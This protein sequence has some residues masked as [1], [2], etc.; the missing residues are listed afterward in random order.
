MITEIKTIH[1][2]GRYRK[3][4]MPVALHKNQVIFGFNGTG[5][6]TMSDILY[7]LSD[8]EHCA[9]LAKRK[10]LRTEKGDEPD[11]MYIV[12]G[13]ETNDLVYD[14]NSWNREYPV[15]VFNDQYMDDYVFL[16]SGHS[17][18][19][20]TVV[21]GK[22]G[23]QLS[24]KKQALQQD[25][26]S[27]FEQV[28]NTITAHKD[29]CGK[30][31]IGK[32]KIKSPGWEKR[33]SKIATI[34][35]YAPSQKAKID[36]S[37]RQLTAFDER[38]KQ[39]ERW[40]ASM[41]CGMRYVSA[42]RSVTISQLN[43]ELL[44]VPKVTNKEIS[45]H[46]AHFM[47][48]TDINWLTAGMNYQADANHCPFCGQEI[49]GNE[50]KKLSI[51][52]EKFINSRQKQK[53]DAIT[54]KM[55]KIQVFFDE[56][57]LEEIFSALSSIKEENETLNLL[58]RATTSLLQALQTSFTVE[59]G[60]FH[61]LYEKISRKIA[62]PYSEIELTCE[63]KEICLTV[64]KVF[65]KFERFYC[66]LQEEKRKIEEKI[67]KSSEYSKSE[68]LYEASYGV[69]SES[70]LEIIGL[71]KSLIEIDKEIQACQHDIDD[72]FEEKKLDAINSFLS[73]LNVNFRVRL[74]E[75]KYCVQILGFEPSEYQ[76]ENKL[77][78]SEGERRMLALA[79]FLQDIS[80]T[81]APK[82]I[83]VDDPISSLD[84][85]RK[86]V[87]AFKIVELMNSL[88]NQVIV[89]SHDI[90]FVEKIN[91]LIT[92]ITPD[93]GMLEL[94]KSQDIPFKELVLSD[95]LITDEDVYMNII[96]LSEDSNDLKYK[97]VGLMALRPYTFIK[98]GMD[99]Y[100]PN[101]QN[102]ERCSTHLAHSVYSRSSRVPYNKR[103]YNKQGM[104]AYC[105][106][107]AKAT[108]ISLNAEKMVPDDWVFDGFDYQTAWYIY[109]MIP[110]SS[111]F[112][113]RMK[114]MVFRIVLEA[115]LF[116]LVAKRT[117]NPERIGSEYTKAIR[118][119][120]GEK[121]KQCQ[122][123]DRLYDLSKKYHHGTDGSSTLGLAALNPDEMIYFDKQIQEVHIWISEN[124]A[125]CNPNALTE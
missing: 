121:K 112:D 14:N 110:M 36:E 26:N 56:D 11:D 9:N 29:L 39:L 68:A 24:K 88:D 55:Q 64:S 23:T 44:T 7:S 40:I 43:K 78:C 105:K 30:L 96:R 58:H 16:E 48:H 25:F 52:L 111:V 76:K 122:E 4:D 81:S 120:T 108:K 106:K 123:L 62:N 103:K 79:Y 47:T 37:L 98:T 38:T 53:A 83:V 113:L 51:Q 49:K 125:S 86:S 18:D 50:Y 65:N 115:S 109:S 6:S 41:A 119:T 45:E 69:A 116:M 12:F 87:V 10:T 22:T 71:S 8:S 107:V 94:C 21:F 93:V 2:I 19:S 100:Q 57:V 35:L 124:V 117:F 95:Y 5:K 66:A 54:S 89:L 84:L 63:E 59:P 85:S 61:T 72:L 102:I 34:K 32:T 27:K 3:Y 74:V 97:I 118:G 31:D 13:T 60:C 46:I 75:G 99:I 91:A 70:I 20:D 42:S 90:S 15:Y 28:N 77:L 104:R 67:K 1:G 33:I 101:Y 80:T 114:A 17:I 82:I 92:S 73:E